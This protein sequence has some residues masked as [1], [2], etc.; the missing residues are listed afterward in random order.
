MNR[1]RFDQITGRYRDTKIA[2]V[3]DFSEF[4][5]EDRINRDRRGE[6]NLVAP[7]DRRRMS[8]PGNLRFP[9][10]VLFR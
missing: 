10:N 9:G 7:D 8:Q 5:L 4:D 1:E 2:I 6:K 3:G